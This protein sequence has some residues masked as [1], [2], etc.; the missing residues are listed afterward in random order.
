MKGWI[1]KNPLAKNCRK[2]GEIMVAVR[3]SLIM[4]YNHVPEYLF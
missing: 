3:F 1:L 2:P 4:W